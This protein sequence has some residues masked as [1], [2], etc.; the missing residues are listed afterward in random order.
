[1]ETLVKKGGSGWEQ[2]QAVTK[3]S[4]KNLKS[5]SIQSCRVKAA[6]VIKGF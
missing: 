1:M 4:L 5:F 6:G 2:G 3:G